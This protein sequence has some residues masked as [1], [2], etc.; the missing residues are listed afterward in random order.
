MKWN[1]LFQR[2]S[3]DTLLAEMHGDNRLHRVLG[4]LSLTSLGVGAII[5]AGIFAMTGRVAAEDAGPAVMLSFIVAGFACALAALCYSEFAAMVPVAGSAY[6]Y[7]YA[8]L[9]E[10][11]AWIIGWDLILEYAMSCAVVAAHW[12]HYLDE[13]LYILL[14]VHLP[15]AITSD[16]F[17]P[18]KVLVDGVEVERVQAFCNL[19][20]MLIIAVVTYILV[21]GIRQSAITN[22]ILVFVKVGVVLFV[23]VLGAGYIRAENWTGISPD[24]RKVSDLGD[25]LDRHP[26]V[27]AK[28]PRDTVTA[29]TTGSEFVEKQGAAL[30]DAPAGET[31][32]VKDL[33]NEVKKWGLFGAFGVKSYLQR[34]DDRVRSPFMPYGFSGVMVGAALVFF[35]YI[36]FDSISTHSEEAINPQR[37]IPI[38]ILTSLALCT[39]LYMLVAAV[40]TGMEPYHQIDT[41]A[42]IAAAFR[43]QAEA[44]SSPLLRASAGLIATGALA[45]MTSV[46]LV[47]FLSQARVFLAMARDGLL[48][49]SIFAAVHPKYRTPH[50]STILTGAV[51][52]VSA[53]FMPIRM[54]E[55][56]V[57][58]GTLMAF[59]LVC[60]S[61]LLLRI[62]HPDLARPF[63][64]PAVFIVAPVGALVNVAMMLFLPLDTW[65]R[66][67]IW[68]GL[69]LVIYLAYGMH[70]STLRKTAP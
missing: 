35:A 69:G 45:G 57:S 26:D 59:A 43:K 22:T 7:T 51:I 27:A 5:G 56:M 48:P 17:T 32:K 49:R 62:R 67:V 33:P 63:R 4:P 9:G 30:A 66:L 3:L 31:A 6:T 28:V 46:L 40:I 1:A 36:G 13:F 11:A 20:A 21:I 24:Q 15:L 37:D 10:L 60:M 61:V 42:A 65:F 23:I 38:G 53:G 41:G 14:G 29:F 18:V 68:L 8:T 47:T 52:A 64:C 2:K 55:E 54:L 58:I 12:T 19:P 39:V 44:Q 25:Y 70:H 50:R 16:P 34:I